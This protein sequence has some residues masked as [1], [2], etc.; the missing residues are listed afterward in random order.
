MHLTT[1]SNYINANF[2]TTWSAMLSY[3]IVIL[4]FLSDTGDCRSNCYVSRCNAVN[5]V[6]VCIVHSSNCVCIL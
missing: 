5:V 3:I 2:I 4:T 1:V 6:Y